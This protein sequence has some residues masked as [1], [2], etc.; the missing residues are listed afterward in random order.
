MNGI[1]KLQNDEI[2][3]REII[4]I[5]T[6]YMEDE[7]TG[8]SAKQRNS[9]QDLKDET[10]GTTENGN[11]DNDDEFNPTLAAMETEI[12]PKVLKTISNLT[13]DYNKLIKYQNE[14][15]DCVLT[16][17]I[18]SPSKEKNYKKIVEDILANIKSLQLSPSVL[19]ELVQKHYLENKKIVSLEGNLLRLALENKISRNEFIKFYIG[20]EINPNLKTFLNT[21][22]TWKLFFNKNKDK[23]KDIRERLI[24][25]SH[26]LGLSVTE[27]KK[28][29]SR[30]QKGRKR[31]KN[32]K[33]RNG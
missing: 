32:S 19:E 1:K 31:V 27:F 3:V 33:K 24:E 15:L 12:K 23:F 7:N 26:K 8:Q 9:A 10:K 22:E 25:I 18:F 5:D 21:N 29:V 6:N 30:V 14:K 13:K 16:S 2:L 17:K 4:D 11:D 20:N 28:L